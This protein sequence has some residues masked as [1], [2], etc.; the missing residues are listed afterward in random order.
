MTRRGAPW[1]TV[2]FPSGF[3]FLHHASEGAVL[4]DTGYS[5][6]FHSETRGFPGSLYAHMTP[7]HLEDAETAQSQLA[8][9]GISASDVRH[10]VLSHFHADHIAGLR[11]FP[12]ARVWQQPQAAPAGSLR[13]VCTVCTG[14]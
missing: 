8:A 1:R 12:A 5:A 6:R 14:C 9:A 11:D 4:F 10:V 7:V 3:A 2:R 13:A